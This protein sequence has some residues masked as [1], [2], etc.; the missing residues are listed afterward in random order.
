MTQGPF[1]VDALQIEP[2]SGQTLLVTRD[3]TTGSLKFTDVPN[4]SGILLS[5]LANLSTISGVAIVGK[6]GSGAKYTTIQAAINA[7][8]AGTGITN[9]FLILVFP[10]VYTEQVTVNK[11]GITI[12][13]MGMPT[14]AAPSSGA[15]VILQAGVTTVPRFFQMTGVRVVNTYGTQPCLDLIGSSSSTVGLDGITLTNCLMV[16]AAGGYSIRASTINYLTVV[17]SDL[18]LGDPT[19]IVRAS[20]CARITLSGCRLPPTQMDY[21][22][23]GVVPSDSTSAYVVT[24]CPKVG[25]LQSTLNGVGSLT[26]NGC[27]SVVSLAMYG[28]RVASINGSDILGALGINGTTAVSLRGSSKGSVSGSGTLTEASTRGSAV[29]AGVL[30]VD[31]TFP[32]QKTNP[33]YQVNLDCDVYTSTGIRVVNKLVT[34]F[35]IEF[36]APQTTT[37]Y[38]TAVEDVP[39]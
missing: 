31:V 19:A 27:P 35:R 6:A 10:G 33:N 37:V 25:A 11:D 22:S 36:T 12:F 16:P 14:I 8:P 30:F 24:N 21:D 15:T 28:N 34:G 5:D 39:A 9:P 18:S 3:P 4:P 38:W 2:G 23:A 29:F 1:K 26:V 13:G 20:Q 32:V 7:V 17:N